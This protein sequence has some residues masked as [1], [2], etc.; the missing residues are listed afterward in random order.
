MVD[1]SLWP[2]QPVQLQ[3]PHAKLAL[4]KRVL[5]QPKAFPTLKLGCARFPWSWE[6]SLQR[7]SRCKMASSSPRSGTSRW[8][9]SNGSSPT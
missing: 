7:S 5:K 3:L 8:M 4:Q 6:R 1:A 9:V 2:H